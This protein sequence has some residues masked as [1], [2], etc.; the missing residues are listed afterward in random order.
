MFI[1]TLPLL[2]V[3]FIT[4]ITIS[5]HDDKSSSTSFQLD[6]NEHTQ[7]AYKIID[8][9]FFKPH[10]I[11]S[12]HTHICGYK[13]SKQDIISNL[14]MAYLLGES[15]AILILPFDVKKE[16]NFLIE[17][18]TRKGNTSSCQEFICKL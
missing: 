15:L 16:I 7:Q 3:F 12:W 5:K 9:C 8:S 10:I 18:Y 17:Y 1:K 13:F 11:G 2:S 4:A 14:K 6:G